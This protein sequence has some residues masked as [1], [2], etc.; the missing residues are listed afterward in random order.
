MNKPFSYRRSGTTG[1]E[2][3]DAAGRVFAWTVDAGSAA[4][5]VAALNVACFPRPAPCHQVMV[6][7]PVEASHGHGDRWA[8]AD[9]ACLFS[10]FYQEVL[11]CL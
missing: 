11:R 2:I 9:K 6:I 5:I 8:R 10:F 1:C 7:G 4:A 3:I